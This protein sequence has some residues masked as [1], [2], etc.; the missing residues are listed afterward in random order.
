MDKWRIVMTI[1]LKI[2]TFITALT[3]IA[4]ITACGNDDKAERG[5]EGVLNLSGAGQKRARN[6]NISRDGFNVEAMDL[7]RDETPDQWILTRSNQKRIERDLNFDGQVDVW[8]YPDET[9]AIVEEEMDLDLDGNVDLV[10]FYKD[11]VILRKE[12]STDFSGKFTIVKFYDGKGGLLRI[13]RDEDADGDVDVWEYY[14]KDV[15]VRIGWD[16][17]DDGTPDDF[18]NFNTN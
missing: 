4:S 12:M 3:F 16:S 10:V 13:E 2:I 18:D 5:K 9:G 15:R 17:D 11:G 7:N 14:E 1:M 6:R 8:Q